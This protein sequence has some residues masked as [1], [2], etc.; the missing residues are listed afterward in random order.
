MSCVAI[1]TVLRYGRVGDAEC[2]AFSLT[3]SMTDGPVF[4]VVRNHATISTMFDL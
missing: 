3:V 2:L 1:I 4:R